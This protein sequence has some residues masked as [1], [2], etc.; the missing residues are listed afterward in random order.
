MESKKGKIWSEEEIEF[1]TLNYDKMTKK[2][3]GDKI[4][5]TQSAV[6]D[7]GKQ[8]GLGR[9]N[10]NSRFNKDTRVCVICKNEFPRTSEYF[11]T[12]VAK[13]DKEVFQNK[14]RPCEKTYVQEKNSTLPKTLKLI[15][16]GIKG[17]EKRI[18]KG[19][20][21]TLDFL[22]E[23]WKKQDGKCALTGIEMTHKKGKGTHY[24]SSLS[25]DRIDSKLGYVKSNV[26][27]ACMWANGAKGTFSIE[28]FKNI[29]NNT[30]SYLVNKR[31]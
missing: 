8:I 29:I 27:L 26:Q 17:N 5:R 25:I 13:R 12:F 18:S 19:F 20:D 30:N 3:L 16:N 24:F 31:N 4:G 28:E 9:K 6:I 21:L 11:T 7:K 23:L 15:L 2:E 22:L 1:I 14:C 10:L